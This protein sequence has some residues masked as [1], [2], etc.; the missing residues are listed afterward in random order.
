[1]SKSLNNKQIMFAIEYT[2]DFNATQAAIRAGYSKKSAYSQGH[3]LLK[4]PEID[5]YVRARISEAAMEA[6]EVLFHLAAIAR[7][8]MQLLLDRNG[9]PDIESAKASGATNLIKKWKFRTIT[10]TDKDGNGSDIHEVEVEPY[11]RLQALSLLAKHH[12]LTTTSRVEIDIE[13][14]AIID[15]RAG[16]ITFDALRDEFG[17]EF[18]TELFGKAGIPIQDGTGQD[19]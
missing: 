7:G 6:D 11:D 4:K 14:K 17:Y 12:Q 2:K 15:I 18:A 13:Q 10:Q 3:E 16:I 8:D 5:A 19:E 1:M 9:L